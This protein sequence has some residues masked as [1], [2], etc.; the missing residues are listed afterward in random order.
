MSLQAS[1]TVDEWLLVFAALESYKR[2][3][4]HPDDR[5]WIKEVRDKLVSQ[6]T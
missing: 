1:L 3:A 4:T 6:L 2:R 5:Q